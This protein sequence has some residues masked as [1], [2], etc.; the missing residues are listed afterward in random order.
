MMQEEG[1]VVCRAFKKRTTGQAKTVHETWDTSYFYDEPPTATTNNTTVNTTTATV[2]DHHPINIDYI[3]RHHHHQPP[4]PPPN[5]LHQRRQNTNFLCKQEIESSENII[6]SFIN[7]SSD[8]FGQLP[9]LESPSMP[10]VKRQNSISLISDS[11]PEEEDGHLGGGSGSSSSSSKTAVT[12]DWRALDKFVASQ[13]SHGDGVGVGG[14]DDST[15]MGMLLMQSGREEHEGNK[16]MS[17]LFLSS[18]S[19]CDIGICVFDHK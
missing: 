15:E 9:Q 10:L 17:E 6:N 3:T 7:A 11:S 8:P 13:L 18:N 4:P 5:F 19:D 2:V 16:F 14:V 1:W 12:T